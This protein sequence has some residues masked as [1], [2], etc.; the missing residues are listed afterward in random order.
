MPAGGGD[1]KLKKSSMQRAKTIPKTHLFTPDDLHLFDYHQ[2]YAVSNIWIEEG[3]QNVIA[4]YDLLVRD[5]P[6][7][8]NFLLFGGLEELLEGIRTWR[9]TDDEVNYLLKNTVI[10]KKMADA[11]RRFRF[12]GDVWAMPEGTVFFPGETVVRLTGPIWEINLLTMFLINT[13]TNNTIFLSKA[14]RSYLAAQGKVLPAACPITR[15]HSNESAFKYGRA[16]YILG[17]F[18]APLVPAF[19]R[20]YHLPMS[21][22]S[23]KA[24]H[25][26]IKSFSTE[27]D[28]MRA[29]AR[30]YPNRIDFMIDTY[31]MQQGVR[32]AITI[33]KEF[34]KKGQTIAGVT[35]D[36][37][38][39]AQAYIQQ[40]RWTRRMFDRAGFPKMS[41]TVAGNFDEYKIAELV[42]AKAPVD[43]VI[44]GTEIVTSSDAPKLETVLKLAE[45]RRE[46]TV[47][48]Q[49]KLAPGKESYPGR[50]Q[51]YRV[52]RGGK[53]VRDVIGLESER[54][55]GTPLL[56]K[57][58]AKGKIVYR[59]PSLQELQRA[60]AKQL[61]LLP[62]RLR[63]IN[64][65]YPYPVTI[66]PRLQQLFNVVK[67]THL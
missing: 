21:H 29:A 54:L 66:S 12:S 17:A 32:N 6:P 22:V 64:R 47:T 67:K 15:G 63:D 27:L 14:V 20:K 4:T 19:A 58:V 16:V 50:K 3:M 39:D 46:K 33:A 43:K 8:R 57:V 38:K 65:E 31:D 18:M 51:V 9:Y 61:T 52:F 49:A 7:H 42:K 40:A 13:L 45:M 60:V 5:L 30:L 28:A 26:V 25:A 34:A 1:D 37:G 62:D 56:K 41:I 55:A 36:S 10:T 23:T 53:M 48:Y 44:I 24:Y 2:I 59:L 11:M 35:I